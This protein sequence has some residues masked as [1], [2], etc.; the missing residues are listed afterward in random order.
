VVQNA[1]T[2]AITNNPKRFILKP[3]LLN[4][5]FYFNNTP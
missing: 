1:K 4:Y 2:N 5:F 3:S